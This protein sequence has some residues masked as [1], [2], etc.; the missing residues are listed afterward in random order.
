MN[1]VKTCPF[2]RAGLIKRKQFIMESYTS[3]HNLLASLDYVFW[4]CLLEQ[5]K[6]EYVFGGEFLKDIFE[7]SREAIA[8]ELKQG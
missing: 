2:S 6:R 4:N 3:T 5:L 8:L 7:Y 1:L